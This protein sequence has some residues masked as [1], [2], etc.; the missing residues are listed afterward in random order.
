M[1]KNKILESS[2]KCASGL[3]MDKQINIIS[4]PITVLLLSTQINFFFFTIYEEKKKKKKIK[5]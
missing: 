3:I 2:R 4:L 5:K 1:E